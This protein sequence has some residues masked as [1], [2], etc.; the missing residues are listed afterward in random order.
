[1]N[2]IIAAA[3]GSGGRGAL[4][5][6]MKRDWGETVALLAKSKRLPAID[7]PVF[8]DLFWIERDARRDPDNIQA[9]VKL[10]LDGLVTAG[11]LK[12]DS[13]RFV[14][15]I[16]HRVRVRHESEEAGVHVTLVAAA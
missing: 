3:K 13:Q 14:L 6:R 7:G 16:T 4:Y 15:G 10:V 2:E 11:V 1:M 9:G 5:A 12:G 8:V